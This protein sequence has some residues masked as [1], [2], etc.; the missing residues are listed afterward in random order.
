MYSIGIA[1]ALLGV[2]VKTL[3]RW[4]KS[5]KITCFRTMGGHRRF[6]IKEI[7]RILTN[8]RKEKLQSQE[9]RTN[10]CAIYARVSSH[11]QSKR[12]DLARQIELL[13]EFANQ[14]NL[15]V[16]T[17]YKDVGSGLNMN[18]KGMWRLIEDSK[19]NR[20]STVLINFKDRLTRFGYKY[21]EKYLSEFKVKI[22]CVNRLDDKTPESELVEDL[23]AIVHSFSG[24]LYRMRRIEKEKSSKSV[25]S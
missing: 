18:R 21:L 6:S 24:K 1:A 8:K 5:K 14:N 15:K 17:I 10:T 13:K 4:D 9:E 19:K 23:V 16:S 25:D 2:C 3:R 11:K 7:N 12:G 22:I 20:F